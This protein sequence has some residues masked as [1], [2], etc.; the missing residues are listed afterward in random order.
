V[1]LFFAAPESFLSAAALSHDAVASDAHLVMKLFSAAPASFFSSART[2]QVVFG[3]GSGNGQTG[4]QK[5]HGE[6]FHT[7]LPG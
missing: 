6:T 1:K 2:L 3:D 4:N 5:S 7:F